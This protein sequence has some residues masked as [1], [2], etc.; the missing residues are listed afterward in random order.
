M[1]KIYYLLALAALAFSACQKEPRL[2]QITVKPPA[3]APT[4]AS[5]TLAAPDYGLLPS[6]DPAQTN[7][8]F[9]SLSAA[10]SS[11]PTILNTEYST[12]VEKSQ[13]TVTFQ[14]E[15]AVPAAVKLVDSIYTHVAYTLLATPAGNNDY[16]KL[17]KNTYT[18][19]TDAQILTWFPYAG[20][21]TNAVG[22]SWGEPVSPTLAV[23]TF[24]YYANGTTTVQTFAYLYNGTAWGKIYLISAA[25]YT[26][27]GK[28]GTSNDFAVADEPN[29]PGY[30]S[31]ILN[32]DPSVSATAKV[33]SIEYVSYKLYG[34]SSAKT[35]QLVMP[36]VFDGTKWVNTQVT[37]TAVFTKTNG[38]W[39]GT[40]DNTV[41]YTLVAADYTTISGINGIASTAAV[42]DLKSHSD[43]SIAAGVATGVGSSWADVQIA[44][45][46]IAILK[47]LYTAPAANQKFNVT[48]KTYGGYS[49]ETAVF[50]FDG[51]NFVY[52]PT[53]SATKYT[54]TGDDYTAIANSTATGA[55]S[56]A[57]QNL[58]QYGDFSTSGATAWTQVQINTGI[59]AQLKTRYTTATANQIVTVSYAIYSGGNVVTTGNFK[60]D[61]TNWNAQ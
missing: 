42:A 18:D 55:T 41:S 26:A 38:Q 45:G 32:A 11:V 27:I 15:P 49:T 24:N 19:F 10:L 43:F 58:N 40:T 5:D 31:S 22:T 59:A 33:G 39:V 20:N 21:P 28:G 29:L 37:A 17:P 47:T 57:M 23:P 60:Y 6:S 35:Y 36:M 53:P 3:T 54:L 51:T 46:I 13:I 16:T 44:N 50:N 1:K 52:L 9:G 48:F 4:T 8:F 12:A 7:H 2:N 56:S 30:F 34:G 14:L 25:Q 61:G